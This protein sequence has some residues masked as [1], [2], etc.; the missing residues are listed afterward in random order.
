[1]EIP[2]RFDCARNKFFSELAKNISELYKDY[3]GIIYFV[4]WINMLIIL[5][6]ICPSFERIRAT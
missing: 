3:N 1:M 6:P 5:M 2:L 4:F